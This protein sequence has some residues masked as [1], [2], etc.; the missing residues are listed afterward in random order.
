MLNQFPIP[1]L[2]QVCTGTPKSH[3]RP[4]ATSVSVIGNMQGLM[5]VCD[6]VK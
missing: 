4:I 3:L 5:E 2:V 6:E 1:N